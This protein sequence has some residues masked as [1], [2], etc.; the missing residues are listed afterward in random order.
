MQDKKKR[1]LNRIKH[2]NVMVHVKMNAF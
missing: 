1:Y 2:C